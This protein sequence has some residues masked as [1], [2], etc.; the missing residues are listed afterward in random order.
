MVQFWCLLKNLKIDLIQ[1]WQLAA[2]RV[3]FCSLLL[4][5]VYHNPIS[6]DIRRRALQLK[7]P[8]A[9]WGKGEPGLQKLPGVGK[10]FKETIGLP[11]PSLHPPK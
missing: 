11:P 7:S 2:S 4:P 6:A 10:F 3:Y 9:A 8:P 5:M 1:K